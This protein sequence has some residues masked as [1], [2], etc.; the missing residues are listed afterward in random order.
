MSNIALDIGNR[1]FGGTHFLQNPEGVGTLVSIWIG[2]AVV[3]AGVILVFMIIISG[4][5]MITGS[6]NPQKQQQA[7]KVLTSSIIGFILVIAAYFIVLVLEISTG[8]SIF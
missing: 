3:V 8:A 2:D 4:F 5:S 7:Q 1:F 6:G